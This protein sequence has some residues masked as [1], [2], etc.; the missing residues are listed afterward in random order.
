[1]KLTDED[2]CHLNGCERYARKDVDTRRVNHDSF[3]FPKIFFLRELRI[4]TLQDNSKPRFDSDSPNDPY[5]S[6]KQG[7]E[8][9]HAELGNGQSSLFC[10][11]SHVHKKSRAALKS[12][13][14]LRLF[15]NG[16]LLVF[17]LPEGSSPQI[18]SSNTAFHQGPAPSKP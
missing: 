5:F 10:H 9:S 3:I 16:R 4:Q 13:Y 1:M 6:R 17:V 15:P 14:E 18:N 12:W 11:G 8:R 2:T 7:P